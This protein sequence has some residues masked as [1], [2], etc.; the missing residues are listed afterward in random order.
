MIKRYPAPFKLKPTAAER[1]REA[2]EDEADRLAHMRP[3]V[4]PRYPDPAYD[5]CGQSK[6]YTHRFVW[7][8]MRAVILCEFCGRLETAC[9]RGDRP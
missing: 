8:P 3:N 6:Y 5:E 1:R 9:R 7:S 2:L 4:A